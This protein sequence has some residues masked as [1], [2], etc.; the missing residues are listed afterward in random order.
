MKRKNLMGMTLDDLREFVAGLGEPP[1]RGK[2]LYDWLYTKRTRSFGEMT[3]LSKSFRAKLAEA[4]VIDEITLVERQTSRTDGATKLLFELADGK[5]IESVLIPWKTGFDDARGAKAADRLTLCISTQVG[6]PL[7]CAFCATATMGFARNLTSAEIVQQLIQAERI[8]GRPITNLVYMGMGEPLMNYENVIRSIEII[9]TAMGIATRR[10]TISTAGWADRIKQ[11]AD[12]G[13]KAKLAISLHSLNDSVRTKLMPITKKFPVA[14]L[15][16]AVQHHYRK[17]K[18]R[19]TYEY[20][21]F[22]GLNDTDEDLRH[23]TKLSR[24]VPCK[25]NIVPFHSIGFTH[26]TGF[27]ASLRPTP[28]AK[29]EA[30][31]EKLRKAHITVFVRSSAGEDIDAACGQLAVAHSK[32]VDAVYA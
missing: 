18:R 29:A 25:I 1:F 15:I 31:V 13:C 16:G 30:F 24:I 12:D 23:L 20:I 11:L 17:A 2:Q 22:D 3:S 26:S 21:L 14:E 28:P 19:V 5:R 6:C 27:S 8:A 7:D 9:S 4:A 32:E 10:I